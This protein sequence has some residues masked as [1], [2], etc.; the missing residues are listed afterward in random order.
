MQGVYLRFYVQE[1]SRHRGRLTYE[2][3]L[4]QARALGIK[5]GSA[6]R[7]IAG[8]GR[9]GRLHEAHFFELAGDVPVQVGFAVK[10]VDA[11]RLLEFLSSEQLN[12]FYLR[13]P[14]EIGV[15]GKTLSDPAPDA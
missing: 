4:E 13:L 5:G 3:L 11:E 2:W 6:F 8:F 7:A 10:E 14:V 15:T 9:H 1:S 12:L